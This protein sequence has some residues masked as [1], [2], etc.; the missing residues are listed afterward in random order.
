M[1]GPSPHPAPAEPSVAMNSRIVATGL[2]LFASAAAPADLAAVPVIELA[3]QSRTVVA[4]AAAEFA[5]A[6]SG[7]GALHY[8]WRRD[9]ASL[10]APDRATYTL[11][12]AAPADS[13]AAFSVVV[14]D[15]TG[16]VASTA[17]HL[18]VN[19]A[20]PREFAAWATA[21]ADAT[22][23]GP[24]D[25]PFNDGVANLLKFTLGLAPNTRATPAALPGFAAIPG[26]TVFRHTRDN[27]VGGVTAVVEKTT[28]LAGDSWATVPA[29][30][31]ADTGALST[32]DATVSSADNRAFY[33]LRV[34][35][36]TGSLPSIGTQP[37]GVVAGLGSTPTLSVAAS[38]TGPFTYQWRKNGVL[39]AGANAANYTLPAATAADNGARFSVLISGPGGS[40]ASA[41]AILTV[42]STQY[43]QLLLR[44]APSAT[45]VP[46]RTGVPFPVG[47]VAS[48]DRLR[49]ES[50]DGSQ[51]IPAQYDVLATW[52]DGSIK[53]ALV[54]FVGDLGSATTYRLAYGPSVAHAAPPRA[55]IVS[56]A[57]GTTSVDTSK[58][59]LT[60]DGKGNLSGLWRDVNGDGLFSSDELILQDGEIYL[61]NAAD[62]AEFTASAATTATVTFEEQG[63]LRAVV[64]A[65]GTF[66]N[67]TQ[68]AHPLKFQ[69]RYEATQG[70]D[71]VDVE[72]TIVDERLESDVEYDPDAAAPAALPIALKALGMRWTAAGTEAA[73]YR[74]GGEAGAAYS[75]TVAG[76]HYLLQT[77]QF[78]FVNGDNQNHTF[79][80]SGAGTGARAP[81]WLALSTGPRHAAIL[82]RDF[83][84]QYPMELAVN[85]RVVNAAFFA[86]RSI[87]GAADT[88][89]I[90]QSGTVYRRP[91]TL[92]FLRN[93]GAKTYRLRLAASVDAPTTAALHGL[94]AAFQRHEL[95]LVASPAW[96][97]AS[98]VWGDLSAGGPTSPSEGWDEV[99]LHNIYEPSVEESDGDATMFSWRDHGDRLHSGWAEVRNGVRTPAFYN[100]SH[101]GANGFFR[102]FLRTGEMRWFHFADIATRHFMDLDVAHGP[103]QGYWDTGGQP[104]P[105][106]E[107]KGTAHD[108]IDHETRNLHWGH[109]QVSGL[110]DL[111]LMT[112]D[113]RA[114]EVLGEIG[115]WWRFVAP[116]F[117][118]LPFDAGRDYREAERDF[119]WPLYAMNEYVR[120]TGDSTYHRDVAGRLV[121]YLIQWWQTPLD[122]IG[123]NPATG[124][125]SNAVIGVNNAAQGTGYWTMTL[126][127][128]SNGYN[129]TGTNPWMAG[130]LIANLIRFYEQD[131]EFAAVGQSSGIPHAVLHD[132]LLQCQNYVVKHGYDATNGIFLYSE[133]TRDEDGG[134]HHILYGLAYL[135]RLFKQK[136][137]AG[138]LNH[139]EWYDT[140]PQ[141]AGILGARYD[142]FRTGEEDPGTQSY[143]F[144]GYELF[145]P[146][147]LFKVLRDTTNR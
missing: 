47:A 48:A 126:M 25:T 109:A 105:A 73:N 35:A 144:Y 20:P 64:K 41:E 53:A 111:Y 123:Y 62:G 63:P 107:L 145:Y 44:P 11:P 13:G 10:G 100:D 77:G 138:T 97:A 128:N 113:K 85:G 2:V 69:V 90:V 17:A 19:P 130:P 116:H 8:F 140:Q 50:A 72:M 61:A 93:G 52:P 36:G 15:S 46:I 98:G 6:A 3:P 142:Q 101:V 70:S 91:N 18:T 60:I 49:L 71:K 127:D 94:N 33:R 104:Q 38:G 12:A 27:T 66:T 28:T 122:H 23:R 67:T 84:Q 146:A 86:P 102:Q 16:S 121:N 82:L 32:W 147:D 99:L 120:V 131:R 117:F 125:V 45:A 58:V 129:A 132:M 96:Y 22:K 88:R 57:G 43:L 80:Y 141:W 21:I 7:T 29:T 119:A 83:W 137:A 108:N 31:S 110:T 106:G 26:G 135:D 134:D 89:T 76:E 114:R 51:E 139:P 54:G 56:Q 75:G 68:G 14:T 42:Q 81:G 30:K 87:T 118:P 4:G 74:F 9:G 5:V 124:K 112:G 34:T 40:V 65:R 95:D 143:G 78:S 39:I 24:T 133:T 1:D 92:Y 55:V 79:A 103:R 37:T 59:R 115:N 136:K